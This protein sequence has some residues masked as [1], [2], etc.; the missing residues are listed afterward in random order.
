MSAEKPADVVGRISN[1]E[2]QRIQLAESAANDP[3]MR[4]QE[5]E[6]V[7]KPKNQ[8]QIDNVRQLINTARQQRVKERQQRVKSAGGG[9]LFSTMSQ[10]YLAGEQNDTD[11]ELEYASTLLDQAQNITNEAKKKGNTNFFSGFA[12]GFK[13]APLDGWAMGLQDLKNYSVAKKVMDKVDKGEGLSPSE[14]ALMQALVT[15][16][17][18]QMYYSGDLEGDIRPEVLL[19]NL[20]HSCL[21]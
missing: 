19:P 21:I 4:Q 6:H 1:D 2:Q 17:A 12:R 3:Y 10:A 7:F 18:T 13:D 9:G 5:L 16:A 11:K 20:F 15:N 8:E 14:D